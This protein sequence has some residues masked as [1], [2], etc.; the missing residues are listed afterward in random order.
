MRYINKSALTDTTRHVRTQLYETFRFLLA[1]DGLGL[2]VTDIVL[3]PGIEATYGNSDHVE[4]A[5]CIE[6]RAWIRDLATAEER[7]I[8][9][10]MLWI[11][12][13]GD[14]FRFKADEPTR[15]IC[16]FLPA[17]SGHETG[18]ATEP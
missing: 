12:E 6:G 16:V 17:F 9:P 11:A 14:T 13:K 3:Q 7:E 8:R 5:Y 15:L 2:T 18:L 1:S 4:I 10:G